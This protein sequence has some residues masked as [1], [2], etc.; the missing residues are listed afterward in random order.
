MHAALASQTIDADAIDS[1]MLSALGADKATLK[2][3]YEVQHFVP[4]DPIS[5]KTEATVK[6]LSDGHIFK[7]AKGAPQVVSY[8]KDNY[9]MS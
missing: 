9:C 8:Q 1:A 7:V 3:D 5:K 4:F 6:R 2:N